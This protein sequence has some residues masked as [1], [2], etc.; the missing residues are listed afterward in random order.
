MPRKV[1]RGSRS[2]WNEAVDADGTDNV[3]GLEK[4]PVSYHK[5]TVPVEDSSPTLS[6]YPDLVPLSPSYILELTTNALVTGHRQ[7]PFQAL[8]N[9]LRPSRALGSRTHTHTFDLRP[10]HTLGSNKADHLQPHVLLGTNFK[11]P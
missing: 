10:T 5:E 11:E 1:E 8:V 6:S 3:T 7:R 2:M 4:F 9:R